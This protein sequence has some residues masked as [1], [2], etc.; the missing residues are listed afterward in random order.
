VD[1]AAFEP[2]RNVPRHRAAA[3]LLVMPAIEPG[4]V[5]SAGASAFIDTRATRLAS[6]LL[7]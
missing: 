2:R 1:A 7:P 5:A 6:P 4:W 3:P